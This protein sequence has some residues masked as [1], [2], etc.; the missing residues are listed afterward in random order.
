MDN[1]LF[2]S[3]TNCNFLY[4]VI[5]NNVKIETN[6]DID[7]NPSYYKMLTNVIKLIHNKTK[8]ADRNLSKLNNLVIN[9]SIPYFCQMAKKETPQEMK[10]V[11]DLM[12]E[13]PQTQGIHMSIR[14]AQTTDQSEQ[15]NAI[16]TF[17]S[18]QDR[19]NQ[20]NSLNL[21]KRKLSDS[22]N[23]KKSILGGGNTTRTNSLKKNERDGFNDLEVEDNNI[24]CNLVEGFTSHSGD[25]GGDGDGDD[26]GEILPVS[27]VVRSQSQ[28]LNRAVIENITPPKDR[29]ILR[30][31]LLCIDSKDASGSNYYPFKFSVD[32]NTQRDTT[33]T[34][35]AA[36]TNL[37]LK[38]IVEI[39]LI[40]CI[41]SK[42][43]FND[44][45][46][47]RYI[48][49]KIDEITQAI[50]GTNANLTNAFAILVPDR[51]YIEYKDLGGST[52]L[53]ATDTAIKRYVL[54]KNLYPIKKYYGIPLQQLTRLSIQFIN[55]SGNQKND[56]ADWT[57]YWTE[58]T[59]I[60]LKVTTRDYA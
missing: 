6:V 14:S 8:P 31:H 52:A 53:A 36:I 26:D 23:L 45:S 58:H 55:P 60:I 33:G 13:D 18:L 25:G 42:L 35:A 29:E 10:P 22:S 32:I 21:S 44:V 59:N 17:K 12:T 28:S 15:V 37:P 50:H 41:V 1:N 20:L 11:F 40:S 7:R 34:F 9:K 49:L 39:E 2:F 24:L 5:Q 47:N 51:E 38:E 57:T 46:G 54:C 16:D 30:E 4:K 43:P 48:I 3:D 27:S 19:K 56:T